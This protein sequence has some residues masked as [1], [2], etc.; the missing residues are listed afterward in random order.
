MINFYAKNAN[1]KR[2]KSNISRNLSEAASVSL[3]LTS[4]DL[5]TSL[6][7]RFH[8]PKKFEDFSPSKLKPFEADW[9]LPSPSLLPVAPRRARDLLTPSKTVRRCQTHENRRENITRKRSKTVKLKVK[10]TRQVCYQ[11]RHYAI[12]STSAAS[13]CFYLPPTAPEITT[14]F[15]GGGGAARVGGCNCRKK[16]EIFI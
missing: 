15:A 4:V 5:K 13:K 3:L 7:L 10:Q 14:A 6:F 2:K 8:F 11:W 1:S 12:I 16:C 9:N